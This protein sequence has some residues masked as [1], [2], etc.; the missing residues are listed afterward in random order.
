MMADLESLTSL[1]IAYRGS[2]TCLIDVEMLNR[3]IFRLPEQARR[4]S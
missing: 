3:K 1:T 2:A 4:R